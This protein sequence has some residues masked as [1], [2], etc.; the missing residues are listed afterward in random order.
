MCV[1]VMLRGGIITDEGHTHCKKNCEILD[2]SSD[3]FQR[4]IILFYPS[5][6]SLKMLVKDILNNTKM[7]PSWLSR[8]D[9]ALPACIH[10]ELQL[11]HYVS[12]PP[13]VRLLWFFFFFF[14]RNYS[15]DNKLRKRRG[16]WHW[17]TQWPQI[18]TEAILHWL[19]CIRNNTKLP[20]HIT[21]NGRV[22]SHD[23]WTLAGGD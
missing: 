17:L 20:I 8:D 15:A 3:M 18:D 4:H 6:T 22:S 13:A 23:G 21:V 5:D 2:E 12:T 19:K 10:H 1:L 16:K 9:L 14:L 7:Q 11:T